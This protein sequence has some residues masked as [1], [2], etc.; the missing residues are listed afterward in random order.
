MAIRRAQIAL[1]LT[2]ILPR[3]AVIITPHY[4][5]SGGTEDQALADGLKTRLVA[6][7]DVGATVPFTVRVYNAQGPPPHF[8]LGS[9]TNVGTA[10]PAVAAPR[11]L[12]LCLSYYAGLNRPGFRGRVY[13]PA[14]LLGGS[15][16]L[17]PSSTQQNRVLAWGA[18]LFN[19]WTGTIKPT[20]Y[21]RRDDVAR[22]I[23]TYWCDDEWDIVRSRGLK[24]TARVQAN[25]T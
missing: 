9:A 5:T 20:V 21:S 19:T 24:S 22:T 7:S 25:V 17:R 11:E 10:P 6:N 3:D 2:S 8:P 12:A 18:S 4:E 13:L 14:A 23:T 16:G 1:Q 15:L